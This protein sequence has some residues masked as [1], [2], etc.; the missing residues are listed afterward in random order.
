MILNK[1]RQIKYH[2]MAEWCMLKSFRLGSKGKDF[3]AYP[4]HDKAIT[5][6][7]AANSLGV[8]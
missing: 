2:L 6:K 4:Y 7:L 3:S 5:Y 1:L 8:K